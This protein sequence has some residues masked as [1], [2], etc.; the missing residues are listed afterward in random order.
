MP[1]LALGMTR[2]I[3][4]HQ[5]Y[6]QAA[7]TI[8]LR[9]RN[10]TDVQETD[11][12]TLG[13]VISPSG[14]N[15]GTV[16]VLIPNADSMMMSQHDIGQS[17]GKLRFGA[18]QVLVSQTFVAAQVAAQNLT[19]QTLVWRGQNV[20]GLIIDGL[21]FE[22]AQYWHEEVSGTTVSWGLQVNASEIPVTG[23]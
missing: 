15:T 11:W 10:F 21:L 2:L 6:F 3:D 22:I 18:R 9:L 7:G 19:D 17:M 1:N 12:A 13:F 16:D 4:A 23:P 14:G 5:A 8:Y 20:V